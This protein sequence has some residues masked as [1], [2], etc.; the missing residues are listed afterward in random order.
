MKITDVRITKGDWGKT[1]GL[2]NV[3]FDGVFVV[4]GIKIIEGSNGYFLGM[5]S[6]KTV[7]SEYKDVCFPISKDFRKEMEIVVL[8]EYEG[9]KPKVDE[10][11]AAEFKVDDSSGLPF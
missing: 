2:V 10:E 11:K 4:S 6:R 1:K 8:A 3:T 7:T 5:P 9:D